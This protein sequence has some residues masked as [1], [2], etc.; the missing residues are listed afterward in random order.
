MDPD[1]PTQKSQMLFAKCPVTGKPV[2]AKL[3]G[4]SNAPENADARTIGCTREPQCPH[5]GQEH[6]FTKAE[7]WFL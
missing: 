1:A 6:N 7:M 4:T 5:C 2:N 3:V